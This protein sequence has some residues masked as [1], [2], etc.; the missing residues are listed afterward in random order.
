MGKLV[1][2]RKFVVFMSDETY[3]KNGFGIIDKLADTLNNKNLMK[4]LKN[5]IKNG[6]V[7]K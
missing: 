7:D 5:E 2:D 6:D 3:H 4:K 1:K